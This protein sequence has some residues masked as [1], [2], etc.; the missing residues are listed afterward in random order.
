MAKKVLIALSGGVDSS[1]SAKLLLDA[2]YE[3]HGVYM[4]L[5]KNENYHKENIRKIDLLT[6]YFGFEYTVLDKEEQFNKLVYQPFIDTYESGETPNPCT[7]CNRVMKFGALLE[8]ADEMG[9]DYLATGHYIK[10]D[11]EFFYQ[12]EDDAKDQSYFL[13]NVKKD[14]VKRVIFPLGNMQKS[15][16]KAMASEI[17][18]LAELGSQKESSEICFVETDYI[19]LISK[20]LAVENRGVVLD[21]NGKKIGSH[22]GYMQY[23]IGKRRGFTV[24]GA[25]EPLYV[26]KIIAKTNEIVVA[27]KDQLYSNEFFVRDL[28]LFFTPTDKE[29]R[30]YVKV[31]YRNPKRLATIYFDDVGGAKVV[32]DESEFAIAAG[33]AAVFYDGDRLLGGGYIRLKAEG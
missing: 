9:C 12:A 5:H 28:N 33:Q 29:I 21:P 32:L 16:V 14:A 15:D 17:P 31:R 2:G 3:L 20:H 25:K 18:L 7:I 27:P 11:G 8:F 6:K 4:K 24:A 30:A 26:K 10:T 23:T 13:F 1:M 19:D 22:N